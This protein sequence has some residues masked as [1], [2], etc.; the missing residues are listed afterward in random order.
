MLGLAYEALAA[1]EGAT[2]A[3]NAADEVAVAAFEACHIGYT[4]IAKIVERTLEPG[5]PSRAR[6]LESIF[7]IDGHVREAAAAI[8][9]EIEC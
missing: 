1:G 3:Y 2:I 4:D 7:E 9:R 6:E 8:V 5:W